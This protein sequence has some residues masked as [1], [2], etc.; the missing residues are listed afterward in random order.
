MAFKMDIFQKKHENISAA[1][2]FTL[3][4]NSSSGSAPRPPFVVRLIV[5]VC[6][7]RT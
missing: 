5:S 6:S 7:A 2:G 3:Y 1:K 4:A